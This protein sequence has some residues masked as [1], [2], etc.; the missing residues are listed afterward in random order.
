MYY[1]AAF[2]NGFLNTIN[3]LTNVEAGKRFGTGNG[4]L[5]NYIEATVLSLFLI[6]ITGKSGELSPGHIM[7][8][9]LWVYLG[10]VAG[11]IA[12]VLQITGT[13]KTGA[14]ISSILTLAGN[15]GIA[16]VLDY[17]FYG[18]ASS[19]KMAGIFLVL[20]GTMMVE[21]SKKRS[22]IM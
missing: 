1:I 10:S 11:L 14:L 18:I 6:F 4:A 13:L 8:V 20:L 19:G 7:S 5:I 21:K 2:L 12:Q 16:I 22:G 17:V 15:L 9:P 3:R